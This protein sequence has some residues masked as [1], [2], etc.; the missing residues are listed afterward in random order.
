VRR[1][2]FGIYGPDPLC[3]FYEKRLPQ[4]AR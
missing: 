3:V 1:G 4:P 2:P